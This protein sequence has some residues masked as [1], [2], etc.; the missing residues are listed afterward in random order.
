M[1]TVVAALTL[2]A[3]L[4]MAHVEMPR[5]QLA[6]GFALLV[7]FALAANLRGWSLILNTGGSFL[8]A[9]V[10]FIALERTDNFTWKPLHYLILVGGMAGLLGSRFCLDVRHYGISF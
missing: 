3:L 7:G 9:W 5:W 10:Y 2:V 1:P 8:A 4:R 6:F